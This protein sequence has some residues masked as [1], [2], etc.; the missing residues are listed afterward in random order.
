MS[1]VSLSSRST[2]L[3]RTLLTISSHLQSFRNE[4]KGRNTQLTPQAPPQPDFQTQPFAPN[5]SYAASLGLA[6]SPYAQAQPPYNGGFMQAPPP[7]LKPKEEPAPTRGFVHPSRLALMDA[8]PTLPPIETHPAD[9][10]DDDDDEMIIVEASSSTSRRPPPPTLTDANAAASSAAVKNVEDVW[11]SK[12]RATLAQRIE[13]GT[14]SS[15]SRQASVTSAA[16]S[17]SPRK[18]SLPVSNAAVSAFIQQAVAEGEVSMARKAAV[19][20]APPSGALFTRL[21]PLP[22]TIRQNGTQR[23]PLLPLQPSLPQSPPPTGPAAYTGRLP[24]PTGPRSLAIPNGGMIISAVPLV[25]DTGTINAER[26]EG[27][28]S[29]EVKPAEVVEVEESRKTAVEVNGGN[30]KDGEHEKKDAVVENGVSAG[31]AKE[32][33]STDSEQGLYGQA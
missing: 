7:L 25:E 4:H 33:K 31:D 1:K 10:N 28:G 32:E 16:S 24:P 17:S 26:D 8:K 2:T 5:P 29:S 30:L 19:S 9:A 15:A 27:K 20:S 23:S 21:D 13:T 3:I 11:A 18:S 12:R 22:H 14:S 6:P